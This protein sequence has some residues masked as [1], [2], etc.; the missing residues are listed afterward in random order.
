MVAVMTRP[1]CLS[2][3]I[4]RLTAQVEAMRDEIVAWLRD[5]PPDYEYAR[6]FAT[7]IE[8]TYTKDND[9]KSTLH[10][11]AVEERVRIANWL[12]EDAPQW[13][14]EALADAIERG[15]FKEPGE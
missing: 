11:A 9:K 2:T 4:E 12:R 1:V 3:E 5:M 13:G 10:T 6:A 7:M 14:H 8:N 15:D